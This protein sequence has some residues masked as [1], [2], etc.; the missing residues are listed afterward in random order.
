MIL[1]ELLVNLRKDRGY[2]QQNLAEI[3]NTSRSS[4]SNYE[5]GT[6]YPDLNGLVKIADLLNVST[7][8]LLGR[9][10]YLEGFDSLNN[11][12]IGSITLSD[13]HKQMFLL[14]KEH[15]LMLD[16]ALELISLDNKIKSR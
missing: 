2:T 12:M 5:K 8:Y 9:T 15:K 16:K 6:N 11:K 3:L 7:D 10:T 13:F 4:I 14:D 1:G